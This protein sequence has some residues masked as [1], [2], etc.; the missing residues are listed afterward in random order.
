MKFPERTEYMKR[1]K[2]L[3][4]IIIALTALAAAADAGGPMSLHDAIRLA[5]ENN[6]RFKIAQEKV[7]E[8]KLRVREAW[9]KLWPDISTDATVVGFG[10]DK[11]MQSMMRGEYD[12]DFVKCSIAVNPGNFYHTLKASQDGR[13]IAENE[14]RKIQEDTTIQTI[15]LYY[16]ILLAGEIITLRTDSL[17]ALEENHRVVTAGYR[18]GTFTRLD[19]LRASVAAANEKTRLIN[20]KNDFLSARAALNIHLNREIDSPLD[21]DRAAI[22]A[23]TDEESLVSKWTEER[24]KRVLAEMT[25]SALKNRPELIQI[26]MKKDAQINAA[27]AVESL[28]VW[29]TIYAGGKYGMNQIVPKKVTMYVGD[30][31]NVDNTAANLA[32]YELGKILSPTGWSKNWSVNVGATYRWGG[33]VPVDPAHARADQM[34]SQAK[35]TELEMDDFIRSVKLDIQQGLLKLMSASNAIMSQKG[36]IESAEESLR[37]AIVQFKN[38][39]IDNTKLLDANVELAS[40]KTMYVQALYD[41]QT[42]KA[43]LNRSVGYEYFSY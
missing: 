30:P 25:S 33:L 28:Y 34:K 12:I 3:L 42:A 38:G 6:N 31:T 16:R 43:E 32:L 21:L 8:S 2:K 5:L 27:R 11:G 9:G 14:Q 37:V 4:T 24:E 15:R 41:F 23:E 19:F 29:P 17:K 22:T 7:T 35:Q 13:V 40:A 10:A 39:M 26:K 1:L 36:N 18:I 20:A